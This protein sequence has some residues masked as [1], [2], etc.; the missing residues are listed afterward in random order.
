MDDTAARSPKQPLHIDIPNARELAA[1]ARGLDAPVGS[2]QHKSGD[3]GGANENSN[4]PA[5]SPQARAEVP[6]EQGAADRL[7][8]RGKGERAKQR[9]E[10]VGYQ[11]FVS[12]RLLSE[13]TENFTVPDVT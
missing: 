2:D 1:H 13:R 7:K 6:D 3:G 10:A 11:F 9:G 12:V 5:G 8:E 4:G